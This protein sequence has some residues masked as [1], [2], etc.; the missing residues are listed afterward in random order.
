MHKNTLHCLFLRSQV[1]GKVTFLCSCFTMVIFTNSL[2]R[3]NALFL[4]RLVNYYYSIFCP[5]TGCLQCSDA[6][7]GDGGNTDVAGLHLCRASV[8]SDRHATCDCRQGPLHV[9]CDD[10]VWHNGC[11]HGCRQST[12]QTTSRRPGLCLKYLPNCLKTKKSRFN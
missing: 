6:W 9:L 5:M 11:H 3:T 12:H 7:P 8:W 10:V 4:P 1:D 2:S